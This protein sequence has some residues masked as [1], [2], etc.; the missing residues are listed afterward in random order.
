MTDQK[1]NTSMIDTTSPDYAPTNML[2]VLQHPGAQFVCSIPD[3]GSRENKIAI[4]NAMNGEDDKLNDMIG[5]PMEIVN[6]MA[7][8]VKMVDENT[9]EVVEAVRTVLVDVNGKRY[10]GVSQ[11]I[12][13]SIAKL[14]QVFGPAPWEPSIKMTVKQVKTRNGD[15]KVNTL[16]LVD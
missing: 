8:P 11:G 4:Y 1:N 6:I 15:N 13:N 16:E 14:Y 9:G 12:L 3:D 7:Y 2:D 5:K 10:A